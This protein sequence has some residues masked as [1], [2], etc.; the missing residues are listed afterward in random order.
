MRILGPP[1]SGN[2]IT[3]RDLTRREPRLRDLQR[4]AR[5]I[6]RRGGDP[7]P[8]LASRVRQIVGHERDGMY[9]PVLSSAAA[10]TIVARA[11]S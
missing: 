9:D 4:L 8:A 3:F 1:E 5:D 2:R 7:W 11:L 6:R 10:Y